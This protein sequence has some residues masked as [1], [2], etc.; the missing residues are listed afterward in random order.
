MPDPL[1]CKCK[2]K[3]KTGTLAEGAVKRLRGEEAQ[4]HFGHVCMEGTELGDVLCFT[5]VGSNFGADGDCEQG[6]KT[7]MAIA[8]PTF[9]KL[10]EVWGAEEIS[11]KQKLR[12]YSAAVASI[13][14]F[15]FE[16]W[17]MPQKLE[18]PLRGWGARC[19]ATTTTREA[20]Q[21]HRQPTF[22]L[23]AKLRARR[24]KW[25]GQILRLEPEDS[26]VHQV[27]VAA[28]MH[29]HDLAAGNSRRSLL[30]DAEE[31]TAAEELLALAANRKG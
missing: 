29:M 16:A 10:M 31:Y 7:R 3:S 26:L 8:K 19:L 1:G 13:A 2:P 5:Y 21:V 11:L 30:M 12:L 18:D 28:A 27:L 17:E 14:S 24:L 9:G 25:A 22:D 6:V 23:I 15:G 20:P 4:K